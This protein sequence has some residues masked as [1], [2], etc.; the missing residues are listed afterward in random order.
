MHFD[1]P[2]RLL[3]WR[4]TTIISE[5][6]SD[7][8]MVVCRL[9][10]SRRSAA[11]PCVACNCLLAYKWSSA[12]EGVACSRQFDRIGESA[13]MEA[14]LISVT[15][16]VSRHLRMCGVDVFGVLSMYE[17]RITVFNCYRLV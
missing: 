4:S 5:L 10:E 9:L 16:S 1:M 6:R 2:H 15:L 14:A 11:F 8:D 3:E 13:A 17:K 7:L 12:C